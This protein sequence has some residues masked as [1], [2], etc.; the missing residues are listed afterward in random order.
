MEPKEVFGNDY[1]EFCEVE[2]DSEEQA[3]NRFE[4]ISKIPLGPT[5]GFTLKDVTSIILIIPE[6]KLKYPWKYEDE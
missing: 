3:R 1:S 4:E 6:K 2:A 5:H